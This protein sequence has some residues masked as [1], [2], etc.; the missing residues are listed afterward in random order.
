MD[1]FIARLAQIYYDLTFQ[2]R[3]KFPWFD[4]FC[5]KLSQV[6]LLYLLSRCI[7]NDTKLCSNLNEVIA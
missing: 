1:N 4:A 6:L 2:N 3:S 7:L 5:V